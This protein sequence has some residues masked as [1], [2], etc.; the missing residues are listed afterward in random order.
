MIP[1]CFQSIAVFCLDLIFGLVKFIIFTKDA[2]DL[3]QRNPANH[4][5]L[6]NDKRTPLLRLLRFR[7]RC[8]AYVTPSLT[9]PDGILLTGCNSKC[10]SRSSLGCN[11]ATS[12]AAA[13]HWLHAYGRR[14]L[15]QVT[16]C[17]LGFGVFVDD[18]LMMKWLIGDV[19]ICLALKWCVCTVRST[20]AN[21]T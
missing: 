4:H 18:E 11:T 17:Q 7:P 5:L 9:W 21:S 10:Q 3:V 2:D 16:T 14:R 20:C 6:T 12:P 13:R 8:D 15:H 19:F 1:F